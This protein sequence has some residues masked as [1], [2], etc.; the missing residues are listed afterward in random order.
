VSRAVG[1][2]ALALLALG[3]LGIIFGAVARWCFAFIERRVRQ[4]A[5]LAFD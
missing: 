3:M 1:T 2:A 4:D 5:T